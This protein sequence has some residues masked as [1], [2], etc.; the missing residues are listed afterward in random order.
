MNQVI[1]GQ[2][3]IDGPKRWQGLY[4]LFFKLPQDSLGATEQALV[5]ETK[6]SQFNE[7]LNLPGRS[8]WARK[9]AS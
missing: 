7:F 6:T 1:T 3:T 9:G 2:D 5:V 8:L 4:V